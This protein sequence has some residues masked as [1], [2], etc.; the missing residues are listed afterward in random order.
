[1]ADSLTRFREAIAQML[2]LASDH[3]IDLG[4]SEGKEGGVELRFVGDSADTPAA[5]RLKALLGLAPDRDRFRLVAGGGEEHGRGTI[6]VLP[7]PMLG[8]LNFLAQGVEAPEAHVTARKV[9][10]FRGASGSGDAQSEITG[11]LFRIRVSGTEPDSASVVLFY[12]DHYYYLADD[13][14]ESKATFLLLTQLISL[15][16]APATATPGVGLMIGR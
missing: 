11:G 7:R 14:L 13:D 10:Q 4:R 1:V 9:A 12:R 2:Q 15:H 6:S 3:Q 16:A 5:M 8:A